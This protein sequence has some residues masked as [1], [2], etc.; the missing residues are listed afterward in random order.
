MIVEKMV[1]FRK[2]REKV[3]ELW[4]FPRNGIAKN[5]VPCLL[6]DF[7]GAF[8]A[9][10][11]ACSTNE[12]ILNVYCNGLAVFHFVNANRTGVNTCFASSALFNIDFD[13]NHYL[14]NS[15]LD[16]NQN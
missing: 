2:I 13:F 15:D 3:G 6:D 9:L 14:L 16:F 11:L 4:L 10:H 1:F 5:C 7:D 8:W 12:T